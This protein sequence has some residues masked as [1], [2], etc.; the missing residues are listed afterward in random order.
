[1]KNP[2]E[3]TALFEKISGS[4][5]FKEEYEKLKTDMM[6]AEQET[7]SSYHHRKGMVAFL[8]NT[9]CLALLKSHPIDVQSDDMVCL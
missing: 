3:R 4:E 5:E 8:D 6:Q 9:F 7:Q 2:K 1:M